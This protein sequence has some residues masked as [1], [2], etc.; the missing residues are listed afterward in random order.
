MTQKPR[1]SKK[2][3]LSADDFGISPG[4]SKG[5]IQLAQKQRISATS[6][7]VVYD[8]WE[9]E[10]KALLNFKEQIDIGLHFVLTDA[11]P[12]SPPEKVRSLISPNNRFLKVKQLIN[13]SYLGKV[14]S[15]DVMTEFN[16]QYQR[17]IDFFNFEP[18]FI[19]SHHNAHQ[20]PLIRKTF[21][22]FFFDKNFK[23]T[24][25]VRNTAV[26]LKKLFS[27]KRDFLKSFFI[28]L[29]GSSFKKL[30]IKHCLS[31]NK[32]FGGIYDINHSK[33]FEEKMICF[34]IN[35]ERENGI[36]M[37]HPGLPDD[38]L[39]E[40]D[41]FCSGREYEYNYLASSSFSDLL[42]ESEIKLTRFQ[43]DSI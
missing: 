20:Y 39:A 43:R 7:M 10:A 32:D 31:T 40:R 33:L 16:L 4:V 13:H 36:I 5:I 9:K 3:I 14:K 8:N 15:H 2:V 38:L 25:Y 35:I 37:V 21:I 27:N 19:D 17:F 23:K 42:K 12:L 18:D 11:M 6:V 22:D 34:L 1:A 26:S 30:A 28:S 41:Q 24:P 29:P